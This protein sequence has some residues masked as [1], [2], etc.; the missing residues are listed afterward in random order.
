M[1]WTEGPGDWLW[2]SLYLGFP[3]LNLLEEICG[4]VVQRARGILALDRATQDGQ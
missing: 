1:F 3:L 2:Q 4:G